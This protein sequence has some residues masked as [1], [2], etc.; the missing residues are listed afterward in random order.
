MASIKYYYRS[1]KDIGELTVRFTHTRKIDLFA[2]TKILVPKKSWDQKKQ[3]CRNVGEMKTASKTNNKLLMLEASLI[4]QFNADYSNGEEI[5]KFWLKKAI[6]KFFNRPKH[7]AEDKKAS[8]AKTYFTDFCK[9]WTVEN[10][11]TGKWK[12]VKT[13]EPLAKKSVLHYK[14][15]LDKLIEFEKHTGE[16]IRNKSVDIDFCEAFKEY[17]ADV[18]NYSQNYI[19]KNL[20]RIK[21]FCARAEENNIEINKAF[22]SKMFSAPSEKTYDPYLNEQEI[23]SIFELDLSEEPILDRCRDWFIIGL[24]TGLRVSDFLRLS[25]HNFENGMI[26]IQNQKTRA[27]VTVPVHERVEATLKKRNGKLPPK[28][29]STH[30]NENVKKICARAGIN[31]MIEASILNPETKRKEKGLYPKYKAVSSHICRRSFATNHYGKIPTSTIMKIG[32][33]TTESAFLKY[34]KKSSVETAIELKGYWERQKLKSINN[35]KET[36]TSTKRRRTKAASR[37]GRPGLVRKQNLQG[38]GI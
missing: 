31:Q 24:H 11:D 29:L 7:E 32:G 20:D 34:I 33:W 3:R 8:A 16:K 4:E 28:T 2:R 19:S 9:Q 5:D 18:G 13:K 12:N 27:F 22:K 23:K 21:F 1:Q 6:L 26:T 36:E 17:L 25:E 37:T 14:S 38:T 15:T 30:L 10:F 35:G